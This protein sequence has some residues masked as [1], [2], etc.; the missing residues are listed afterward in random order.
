MAVGTDALTA[1]TLGSRS[2]AIGRRTLHAQNFTTA[3]DANNVAVGFE[4]GNDIT[5]GVQNVLVG[6]Q[7]GDALTDADENVAMG[8]G[9]LSS[10]TLGSKTTALGYNA[11]NAQNFT[12][13]TNSHNTAVGYYAGVAVS[14]GTENT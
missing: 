3:T 11:L 4:A 1:D 7:C 10:D 2:V 8:H 5:T 9:T 13:A 14:T 6:S 12:T